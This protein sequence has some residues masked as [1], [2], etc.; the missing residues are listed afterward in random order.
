M[1]RKQITLTPYEIQKIK[2]QFP[3]AKVERVYSQSQYKMAVRHQWRISGRGS[4]WIGLVSMWGQNR[5]LY[6][7]IN[8]FTAGQVVRVKDGSYGRLTQNGSDPLFNSRGYVSVK[9][10]RDGIYHLSEIRHL[11]KRE[12]ESH[13]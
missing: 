9:G 1:D 11:T 13:E 7:V 2:E 8:K 3:D 12:K 10:A 6:V 4:A 5:Q